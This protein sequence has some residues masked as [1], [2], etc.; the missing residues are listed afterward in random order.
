M[1]ASSPPRARA[2]ARAP[3]ASGAARARLVSRLPENGDPLCDELGVLLHPA[4]QR[5]AA[6]VLPGEAEKTEARDVG[7]SAAM[8]QASAGVEDRKVDPGVVRPVPGRPDDGVDLDL[9]AVL[10]TDRAPGGSNRARLQF[11]AVAALE[12]TRTRPDQRVP[13]LQ[14]A[15]EPRLDRGREHAGLRQPPEEVTARKSL[16]ERCLTR[17]DREDHLVRRRELF[18]DLEARVSAADHEQDS[19][20]HIARPAVARAVCLPDLGVE[21]LGRDSA[22]RAFGRGPSRPRPGRQ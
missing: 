12:L 2:P 7:Y 9:T 3:A 5:R 10:E 8:T 15:P 4:D 22:R 20:R 1:H 21:V 14:A 17:A 16:R 13:M 18:G 11:D 6:R 19:L